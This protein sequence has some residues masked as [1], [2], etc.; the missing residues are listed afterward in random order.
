MT[1]LDNIFVGKLKASINLIYNGGEIFIF[2]KTAP[3][4]YSPLKDAHL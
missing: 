4:I 1:V 2:L 3:C